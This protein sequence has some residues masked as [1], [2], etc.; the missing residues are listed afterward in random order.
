M[1]KKY[2]DWKDIASSYYPKA[3]SL[4]VL[5]VLF[6]F[7]VSPKMEIKPYKHKELKVQVID[8]PPEIKDIVKPPEEQPT[9]QIKQV[10]IDEG[11]DSEDDG[12]VE[13]VDT[14][15]ETTL[16]MNKESNAPAVKLPPRFQVV[17]KMPTPIKQVP[18][19]YPES[20]KKLGIEGTVVLTAVIDEK[21]NVI[22]VEVKKSVFPTLD[23]AAI[24]ALKQWKFEPAQ[25][26]GK[27]VSVWVTQPFV[28][29]L[30]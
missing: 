25:N 13:I 3:L 27:P 5:M 14:I 18:P 11:D 8:I 4:A 21:G 22:K 10:I 2:I 20:V 16:D 19:K 26:N 23:Q 6:M 1:E 28:F 24:N 15:Q 17:E 9:P 12:D 7:L 29:N 30:H